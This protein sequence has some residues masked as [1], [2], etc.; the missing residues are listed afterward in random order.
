MHLSAVGMERKRWHKLGRDLL[1]A[2]LILANIGLWSYLCALYL[3]RQEM[4][5]QT[6]TIDLHSSIT[7]STPPSI[8][9]SRPDH[10]HTKLHEQRFDRSGRFL[11]RNEAFYQRLD[12]DANFAL[13]N[14][15]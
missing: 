1:L 2:V 6:R 10:R 4:I 12:Q 3:S 8:R 11:E 14:S 9:H 5:D 15:F 7:L 13:Q